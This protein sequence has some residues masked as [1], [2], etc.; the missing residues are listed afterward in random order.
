MPAKKGDHLGAVNSVETL[1]LRCYCPE[2]SDCWHLRTA[3]GRPMP[4]DRSHT[5]NVYGQGKITI[6]RAVW[7]LL[8]GEMPKADRVVYRTCDS[9][10]CA[11]PAHFKCG[12]RVAAL[13][14]AAKAGYSPAKLVPL[15]ESRLRRTKANAE[16]RQWI[17]ESAQPAKDVAHAVG[18]SSGRVNAIRTEMLRMPV[19]SVFTLAAFAAADE[20][21]RA[22]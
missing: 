8:K 22:A 3:R 20:M 11:N 18:L 19:A 17:A 10:D 21:R 12:R 15:I 6:G 2:H 14:Q 4:R 5:I 13:R 9:F 16:L 1:R 7:F